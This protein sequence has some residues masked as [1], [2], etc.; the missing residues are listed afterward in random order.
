MTQKKLIE[1]RTGSDSDIPK[2][3]DI[4]SF[5]NELDLPFSPRIL[6]AHRT[7]D[8][9]TS[10]AQM[11]EENGFKVA[12]GAAGGS[13][14]LAGMS[15]S[16]TAVPIVALPVM[17][18][19]GGED[20]LLSMIQMPPGIPN[21]CVGIGDAKSAGILAARIAYLDDEEVRKNISQNLDTNIKSKLGDEPIIN[22]V[23]DD[24]NLNTSL[25]D[26]FG[27]KYTLNS[28]T[29]IS[30]VVLYI[31]NVEK[32]PKIIPVDVEQISI[33]APTKNNNFKLTDLPKYVSGPFAWVGVERVNNGM[34]YA[35]QVLGNYFPAVRTKFK[36]YKKELYDQVIEKDKKLQ[37]E[38]LGI[39]IK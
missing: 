18:S 5:L 7:P 23:T 26:R 34:I 20:A 15:A 28:K 21:G 39:Y 24:E 32:F 1:I 31:A 12:I 19:L 4:Y 29:P 22:I 11:L 6:S 9:M 27:I 14:H 36:E 17:S 2:I 33:A 8:R 38:G 25:L 13:A 35:A 30:P 10:E 3:K 16:E 37:K